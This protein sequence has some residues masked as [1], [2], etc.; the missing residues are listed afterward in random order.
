MYKFAQGTANGMPELATPAAVKFL[1][2]LDID[3]NGNM[4][5]DTELNG[6]KHS[7]LLNRHS[8]SSRHKRKSEILECIKEKL[9]H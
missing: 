5:V 6:N 3:E 8:K 7:F 4:T 1:E 9:I 2:S